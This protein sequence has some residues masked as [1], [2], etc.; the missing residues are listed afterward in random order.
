MHL[1]SGSLSLLV[2]TT[3]K[4][5]SG[6]SLDQRSGS[7]EDMRDDAAEILVQSFLRMAIVG[8]SDMNRDI[9]FDVVRPVFP[10]ATAAHPSGCPEC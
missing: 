7:G 9:L 3:W 6:Q 5:G 10:L 2:K 4:V 8:S 1:L